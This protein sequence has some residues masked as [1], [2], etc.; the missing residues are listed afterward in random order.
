MLNYI[1]ALGVN[2]LASRT[3]INNGVPRVGVSI[4]CGAVSTRGITVLIPGLLELKGF[5]EI[6]LIR[7]WDLNLSVSGATSTLAGGATLAA[8]WL[9]EPRP[10]S[11]PPV[12]LGFH[13]VQGRINPGDPRFRPQVVVGV[14]VWKGFESG[15]VNLSS[16]GVAGARR[17]PER[18][19]SPRA[20]S[21]MS[22]SQSAKTHLGWGFYTL[23]GGIDTGIFV[24]VP[25]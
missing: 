25:G 4:P 17:F 22:L 15:G 2:P 12:W 23:R 5:L 20:G 9:H 13:T 3:P 24:F 18:Q 16:P 6:F 21:M 8:R 19:L 11:N 7:A 1:H 10:I 14:E